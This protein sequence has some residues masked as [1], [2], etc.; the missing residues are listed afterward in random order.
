MNIVEEGYG[1]VH[2]RIKA[3]SFPKK[4]KMQIDLKDGRTII[5]PISSFPS[6]KKLNLL[7][8]QK[9]YMLGNGFSFDDSPEVYGIEQIL[10]NYKNYS[11]ESANHPEAT[12]TEESS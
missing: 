10:G 3:V 7:Q 6:I 4:G 12:E 5:L 9:W 1:S 2:P 8:R 11:H